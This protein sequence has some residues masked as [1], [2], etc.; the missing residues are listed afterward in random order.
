MILVEVDDPTPGLIEAIRAINAVID[1][2]IEAIGV[3]VHSRD[4]TSTL[5]DVAEVLRKSGVEVR[6]LTLRSPTLDD[7]FHQVVAAP[8]DPTA[9]VA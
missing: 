6:G 4:S 5:V 3:A 1:V 2:T 9:V 7:V 8:S